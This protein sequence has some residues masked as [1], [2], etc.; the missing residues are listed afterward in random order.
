MEVPSNLA[1][2]KI[3]AKLWLPFIMILWG[4]CCIGMA[5]VRNYQEL[6]TARIMLGLAEGGLFPG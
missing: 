4:A 2:K 6:L 3:G 5:F 1:L